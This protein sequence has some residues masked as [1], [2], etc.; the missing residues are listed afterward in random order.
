MSC[1]VI[2]FNWVSQTQ[3]AETIIGDCYNLGQ[4]VLEN[5]KNMKL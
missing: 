5:A 4:I 2:L 1:N 3:F